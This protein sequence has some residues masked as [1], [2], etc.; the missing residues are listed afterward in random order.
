[1]RSG[2]IV[3][4]QHCNFMSAP[5]SILI[6]NVFYMLAYAF[7]AVSMDVFKSVGSEAFDNAEDLLAALLKTGTEQ[8]V[9]Q[10]LHRTFEPTQEDLQTLRGHLIP[11][12]TIRNYVVRRQRLYCDFDTFTVDNLFNQ[13]LKTTISILIRADFVKA[14][15][16]S[17]LRR[18][19]PYFDTVT[20][21]PPD[22][23]C[24]SKLRFQRNNLS[25]Q[26][27]MNLCRLVI[28]GC[29]MG[30]KDN[31]G[32]YKL[33]LFEEAQLEW[34]Y[35]S[36]LR[37]YYRCHHT[38][39]N[40]LGAKELSWDANPADQMRLPTMK[41]DVM[42]RFGNK[43]LIIDAK[44]YGKI[45]QYK[46]GSASYHNSNLYQI[47]TYVQ[48]AKADSDYSNLSVEGLLL[49]AQTNENVAADSF[50]IGGNKISINTLDLNQK[51]PKISAQL[52]DIVDKWKAQSN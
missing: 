9:R 35:E 48:S 10:G 22:Q 13:I 23:V 3:F 45:L 32:N 19:L 49:Y 30:D 28:D 38:E 43:L 40:V 1:M 31:S 24:W 50:V 46:F 2:E 6:E 42:L 16:K 5:N 27:L 8:V 51:F 41:T 18:L 29:I 21:V 7:R 52:D 20:V 36:F 26:V 39:L 15:R 17:G 25:Y 4:S 37:E 11:T 44:F 12:E 14:E 33:K 34:V 47:N